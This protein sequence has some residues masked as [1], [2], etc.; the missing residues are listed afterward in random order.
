MVTKLG[1]R[2]VEVM[3]MNGVRKGKTEFL[4][5]IKLMSNQSTLPFRFYRHQFPV[6][7]AFAMT[8]SKSQG[9]SRKCCFVNACHQV[10]SVLLTAGLQARHCN[11]QAWISLKTCSATAWSTSRCREFVP[12]GT[13]VS[14]YLLDEEALTTLLSSKSSESLANVPLSTTVETHAKCFCNVH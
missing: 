4:P 12:R 2:H 8:I 7:L 9:K 6:K 5:R 3:H 11:T 13:F 14:Y 10:L 1:E